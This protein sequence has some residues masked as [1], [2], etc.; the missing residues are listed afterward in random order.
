MP[1]S[2]II[3]LEADLQM[4]GYVGCSPG[5]RSRVGRCGQRGGKGSIGRVGGHEIREV[6]VWI[7]ALEP[8]GADG[9]EEALL[10]VGKDRAHYLLARM[11]R[12]VCCRSKV[13]GGGP[14]IARHERPRRLFAACSQWCE[15][16]AAESWLSWKSP[17]YPG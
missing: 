16:I 10:G 14:P 6:V 12:V 8:E 2:V 9:G 3:A 11:A 17:G 1:Q 7:T 5:I 15:W 4:C 13:E